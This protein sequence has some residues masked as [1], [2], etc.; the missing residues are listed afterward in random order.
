VAPNRHGS[1]VN[2]YP[3]ELEIVTI[4]EFDAPL[5]LV[6]D[7]FAQPEHVRQWFAPFRD[8]VTECTID[9]RV[10]GSYHISS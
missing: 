10:G 9:L 1:A 7:V 4:R 5:A 8:E 3:N 2:E 6:F